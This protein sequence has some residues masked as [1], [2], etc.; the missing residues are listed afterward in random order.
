MQGDIFDLIEVDMS[1]TLNERPMINEPKSLCKKGY[2]DVIAKDLRWSRFIHDHDQHEFVD[3]AIA[4][5]LARN[6]RD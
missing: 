1:Q 5:Y 6:R 3:S 4:N 2:I